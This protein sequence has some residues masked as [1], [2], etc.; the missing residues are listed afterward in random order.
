MIQSGEWPEAPGL[1]F[2]AFHQLRRS[3][4]CS[5]RGCYPARASDSND[6]DA[7]RENCPLLQLDQALQ[8]TAGHWLQSGIEIENLLESRVRVGWDEILYPEWLAIQ[9]LKSERAAMHDSANDEK[10]KQAA[11]KSYQ[12]IPDTQ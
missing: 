9:V 6:P 3:D 11:L 1:R 5:G 7:H 4:L 8:T 10:A 2:L 12:S